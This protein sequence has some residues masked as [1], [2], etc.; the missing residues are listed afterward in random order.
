M[1]ATGRLP[2]KSGITAAALPPGLRPTRMRL[3]SLGSESA[4]LAG[5]E[6]FL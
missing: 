2:L 1:P 4:A 3:S 5:G 6:P